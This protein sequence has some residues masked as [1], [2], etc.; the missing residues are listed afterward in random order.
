MSLICN[1]TFACIDCESTG[2]DSKADHIIEV[3]VLIFRGDQQ[4]ASFETLI[5]PQVPIPKDSQ[6]IHHIS[7]QMVKGQPSIKSVLPQI[8]H[9]VKA[10]PIVGHGI[11]FDIDLLN[12]AA[13]HH[14]ISTRLKSNTR[15][16]TLR[17]ARLYGQ[18]SSNSLENLRCHFNISDEGAHRAMGDVR[19][20]V[21][22]FMHL[23]KQF[24]TYEQM[25][26]RLE[27]PIE[28][29][30]IPL[31]KHKGRLFRDIPLDYL[32][33][34]AAKKFDLDL[35]FSIQKEIGRRKQQRTFGQVT[36]PFHQI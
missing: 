1:T 8:H 5:D 27:K 31:G 20:N 32:Q 19:V 9:L 4:I 14:R 3:A 35:N 15:I 25:L 23:A 7:D 29:R 17:L 18:V 30:T 33:W 16:D 22:V 36:N 24:G 21:A 2:L 13:L 11:G 6:L 34:A 12:N 26:A 10:L 28:M